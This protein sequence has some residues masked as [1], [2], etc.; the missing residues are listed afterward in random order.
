MALHAARSR[1]PN[2]I[3]DKL[4]PCRSM[5]SICGISTASGSA[6]WRAA[7]SAAAFAA[8]GATRP[9]SACSASA[10]RRPISACSAKRPSAASPSCRPSQGVV[11]WPTSRPALSA[12][13]DDG[14]LPLPDA[15]VDRVLLVHALEMSPDPAA[16]A[17]RRLA[18]ARGGRASARGDAEPARPVGAHGHHA[19]RSRPAVL[20][21]ADQ[22]IAARDLVHADRMGRSALCAADPARLVLASAVAWE[23]TGATLSPPFAGVHLVEATKQ[24]YRPAAGAARQAPAGA[25]A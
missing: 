25:R 12:L 15:A 5:L 7:L 19:V 4:Q 6:W 23:R 24:V 9:A 3:R 11:K 18:R 14:D 21:L 1:T 20:A 10:M 8:C 13:V 17:A 2:R 22:S 16:L